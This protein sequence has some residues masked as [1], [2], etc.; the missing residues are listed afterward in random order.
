MLG[1][2]ISQGILGGLASVEISYQWNHSLAAAAGDP[3]WNSGVVHSFPCSGWHQG[4]DK[5]WRSSGSIGSLILPFN[6]SAQIP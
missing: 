2:T 4:G 5:F 6:N 3:F 1:G